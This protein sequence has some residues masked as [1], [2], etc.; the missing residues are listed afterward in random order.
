LSFINDLEDFKTLI[1]N[2]SYVENYY[3][4]K[5]LN[6]CKRCLALLSSIED[7]INNAETLYRDY[8]YNNSRLPWLDFLS[9]FY[10]RYNICKNIFKGLLKNNTLEEQDKQ[11]IV[12]STKWALEIIKDVLKDDVN[13]PLYFSNIIFSG[14]LYNIYYYYILSIDSYCQK[15]LNLIDD[16]IKT[17]G[18]L[19]VIKDE[20]EWINKLQIEI[21]EEKNPDLSTEIKE[22][23]TNMWYR[24]QDFLQNEFIPESDNI[25]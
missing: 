20:L 18:T 12:K 17:R 2:N 5:K 16:Y 13:S 9:V 8:V 24:T 6:Y 23:L 11:Y 10:E 7:F 21:I 1:K 22:K 25:N 4:T 19:N 3:N 14:K 15:S